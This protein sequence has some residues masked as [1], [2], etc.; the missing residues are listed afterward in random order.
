MWSPSV[1]GLT[2]DL[3]PYLEPPLSAPVSHPAKVDKIVLSQCNT[4]IILRVT[5]PSDLKAIQASIEG[6]TTGMTEALQ[7][8]LLWV[9]I[10]IGG[11]IQMP[12]FVEVRP[13]ETKHGGASVKVL[14]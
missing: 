3:R 12:P 7:W 14:E 6:L 5:N 4:Q 11:G 10:V 9:A 2:Y 13:R 8:L 1:S